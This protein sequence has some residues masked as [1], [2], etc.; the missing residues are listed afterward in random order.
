VALGSLAL[1][2]ALALG[3]WR[4]AE[5]LS[6][7]SWLLALASLVALGWLLALHRHRPNS[8][9]LLALGW[10]GIMALMA[11]ILALGLW[12]LGSWS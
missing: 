2:L 9:W 5:W 6:L 8:L 1:I 11:L 3:S 7:G 10:L 4:M 12:I